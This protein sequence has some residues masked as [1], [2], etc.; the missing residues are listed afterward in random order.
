VVKNKVAPPFRK[1]EFDMIYGEGIEA[2]KGLCASAG[3]VL[4]M[5]R[6]RV[7]SSIWCGRKVLKMR[8]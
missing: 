3:V 1:A 7:F 5:H 8:Y 2:I 4:Q 6:K